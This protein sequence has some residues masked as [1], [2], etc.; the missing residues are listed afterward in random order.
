MPGPVP[1]I[2]VFATVNAVID[3]SECGHDGKVQRSSLGEKQEGRPESRP[4]CCRGNEIYAARDAPAF[5]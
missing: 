2:H 3:R 1:G 4:L 5:L